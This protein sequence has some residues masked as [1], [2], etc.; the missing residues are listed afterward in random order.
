MRRTPSARLPGLLDFWASRPKRDRYSGVNRQGAEGRPDACGPGLYL[1]PVVP[2]PW[3]KLAHLDI[4]ERASLFDRRS[5]FA[6]R[7]I[8]Q[9]GRLRSRLCMRR[10]LLHICLAPQ[11]PWFVADR[12]CR[13]VVRPLVQG[14]ALADHVVAWAPVKRDRHQPGV[15]EADRARDGSVLHPA[16]PRSQLHPG[17]GSRS[18]LSDPGGPRSVWLWW[19]SATRWCRRSAR[20]RA[21]HR[22]SIQVGAVGQRA[23]KATRHSGA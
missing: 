9:G 16:V 19:R 4:A 14:F 8:G 15:C 18:P 22:C 5:G 2:A 7:P 3:P 21:D 10:L 20:R 12:R 17:Q 1:G 6:A 13:T 23:T 11:L